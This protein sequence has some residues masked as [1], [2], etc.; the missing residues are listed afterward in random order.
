MPI[1][2][3]TFVGYY[4]ME[5]VRQREQGVWDIRKAVE[6]GCKAASKTIEQIGAQD[7]IPWADEIDE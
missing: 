4:T 1:S 2:R 6:L 3:D 7:S 5:Y